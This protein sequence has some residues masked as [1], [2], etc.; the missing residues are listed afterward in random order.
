MFP[1]SDLCGPG[2]YVRADTAGP[3]FT[4]RSPCVVRSSAV[5]VLVSPVSLLRTLQPTVRHKGEVSTV[6]S[7]FIGYYHRIGPSPIDPGL[8]SRASFAKLGYA[9]DHNAPTIRR[10]STVIACRPFAPAFRIYPRLSCECP[11]WTAI[12]FVAVACLEPLSQWDAA[13]APVFPV[14][15]FPDVWPLVQPSCRLSQFVTP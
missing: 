14:S 8:L 2:F 12:Q 5:A 4:G 6:R 1:A 10:R 9:N 13:R 15:R 7:C 3:L 11:S